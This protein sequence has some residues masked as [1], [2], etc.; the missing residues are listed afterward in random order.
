[1]LVKMKNIKHSLSILTVLILVTFGQ[2]K[3]QCTVYSSNGYQVNISIV[4]DSVEI[5]SGGCSGNW[6]NYNIYYSYDISFS[7]SNVPSSMWTLQ[8]YLGCDDG[9][10]YMPLPNSGG[11]GN[12]KSASNV[13]R[14]SNDCGSATPITMGCSSMNIEISG[15]GISH[16][17]VSCNVQALPVKLISFNAEIKNAQVVLNWQTASE[18]NNDYFT[19][20][21]IS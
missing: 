18:L 7:G 4:A 10:H 1:M 13:T 3:S 5:S 14:Y 8:A 19:I 20:E 11:T 16:Q 17:T 15:P 9:S 2:A 12:L 21:K 6:Y